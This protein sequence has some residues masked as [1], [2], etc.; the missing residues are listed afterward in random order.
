M[1][2]PMVFRRRTPTLEHVVFPCPE[3]IDKDR[4]G[5]LVSM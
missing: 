5:M 1:K 2:A 3:V 4:A